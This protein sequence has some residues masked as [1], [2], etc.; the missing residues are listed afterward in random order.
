MRTVAV[1]DSGVPISQSLTGTGCV[2]TTER[3]DILFG[4]ETPRDPRYI[5]SDWRGQRVRCGLCKLL[6]SLILH[7]SLQLQETAANCLYWSS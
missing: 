6:W 7:D 1:D 4:M 5:V 3:I 2:K